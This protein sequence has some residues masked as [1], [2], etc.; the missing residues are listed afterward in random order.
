MLLE[1]LIAI[2]IFSLGILGVVGLQAIAVQQSTD[3]RYRADA[4]QLVDRLIG[5]MWTSDRT[6]ANLKKLFKTCSTDTC[7]EYLAWHKAVAKALPGVPA[8]GPT[9]P[10]VDVDDKGRVTISIFWRAPA[11]AAGDKPHQYNATAQ[12]Q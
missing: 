10:S 1:V 6:P 12:I 4:A 3:A 9:A 11:D 5:Q 2:L 7:S 8:T